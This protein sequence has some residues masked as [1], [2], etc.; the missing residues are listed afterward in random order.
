MTSEDSSVET[1]T[2]ICNGANTGVCGCA[3]NDGDG[4]DDSS[5][6]G[7]DCDDGNPL[8]NPGATEVCDGV[9][10]DCSAVTVDGA[11]EPWFG[12]LCDGADTDL[13]E[14]GIFI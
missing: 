13:C 10:N 4:Y 5:C 1:G 7:T 8:I 11:D 9:D 2:F 3:D 6:G 12:A 14:E